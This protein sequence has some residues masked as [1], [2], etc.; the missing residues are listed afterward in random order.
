LAESGHVRVNG[1]R[2]QSAAR[3]VRIGDVLTISLDRRVLVLRVAAFATR[4]EGYD[5][6][7][8]LYENI[9]DSSADGDLRD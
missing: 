2:A 7:R 5:R 8:L 1:Q 3:A 6:A 4:R 9:G